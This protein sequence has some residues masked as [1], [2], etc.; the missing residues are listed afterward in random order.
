MKPHVGEY[1]LVATKGCVNAQQE[2]QVVI[3]GSPMEEVVTTNKREDENPMLTTR[4]KS[5]YVIVV[6]GGSSQSLVGDVHVIE[7]VKPRKGRVEK[8]SITECDQ[9]ESCMCTQG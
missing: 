2:L 6:D 7:E 1:L 5:R 9:F 8:V 3:V 4:D